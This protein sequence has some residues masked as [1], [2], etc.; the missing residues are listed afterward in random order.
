MAGAS[1][2]DPRRLNLLVGIV[3]AVALIRAPGARATEPSPPSRVQAFVDVAVDPYDPAHL[4]VIHA[5]GKVY[6][7]T[8]RGATWALRMLGPVAIRFDP[9][10][11]G[12][13]YAP[14]PQAKYCGP[15]R[16]VR[17][18]DGGDSWRAWGRPPCYVVDLIF[19]G[20]GAIFARTE[21]TFT[22][23]YALYRTSD[24]GETWT[25]LPDEKCARKVAGCGARTRCGPDLRSRLGAWVAAWSGARRTTAPRGRR[26]R[27]QPTGSRRSPSILASP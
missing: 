17:S 23:F 10:H 15:Q 27:R 24:D 4:F 3:L 21:Y 25:I 22:A 20:D 9:N 13:V 14:F 16:I 18:T 6:A 5:T 7:T 26:W 12:H 1:S 8:D 11:R 2:R 19:G